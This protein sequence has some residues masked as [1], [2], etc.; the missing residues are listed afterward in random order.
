[1][2]IVDSIAD[3]VGRTPLI[4]LHGLENAYALNGRLLGKAE[5]FN[6]SGSAKDRIALAMLTDA[7]Q[8]GLL[9]TGTCI[10]EP[11]SGNTGVGLAA[12]GARMGYQVVLTMPDTMSRERIALLKAYGAK[13]VLTPGA[14]GMKG[15]IAEAERIAAETDAF[16]PSQFENPENPAVHE[17]T[18]GE[19]IWSD[20]DGKVDIFVAG[21]GT[22]G[23]LSGVAHALKKHNPAVRIVAVEPAGS[24]LLSEGRTGAHNLQG[25]GANFI[26]ATLDRSIIDEIITV[27]EADAYAIG[28][29][30][31][32]CDGLLCGITS[33]AAAYA[34]LT[35]LR[36]AENAGKTVVA[37]LPDTGER[38][39]S[40]KL[41]EGEDA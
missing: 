36:H 41:F 20:T 17:R 29:A 28:R 6:P 14:L 4:E 15:A 26:P 23:T 13:V 34:A 22:G 2:N 25:I 30:L 5:R 33:G 1:M 7:A 16:I 38:Y 39:L 32:A 19:E 21:V 12:L 31:A 11:T 3:L 35:L 10:V 24:P 27:R 8:R 18:T 37:F 40:T 9:R